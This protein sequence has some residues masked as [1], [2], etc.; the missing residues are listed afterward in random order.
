MANTVDFTVPNPGL[1]HRI[2]L[3]SGIIY[4]AVTVI[5]FVPAFYQQDFDAGF[6]VKGHPY[7][8]LDVVS[9]NNPW[10]FSSQGGKN[11]G[12]WLITLL[13]CLIIGGGWAFIEK[14][15]NNDRNALTQNDR[16][17]RLYNW[18][19]ILVRYQIAL[20]MSWFAIAKVFP[21][22]MPF[23]TLSQ[24]NTS[25]G[26]FAP[27]KLYWLTTGVSPFFEVFAG[28]FELIA[29][30]LIL[31]RRTA[32]L[33]A[34]MMIAILLSIWF[35]NIGY[36]AGVELASLHLLFLSAAL[37][38]KDADQFYNIL[39][40]HRQAVISY[41]QPSELTKQWKRAGRIVLKAAFIFL[42]LFYRGYHYEQLYAA[43]KT[44]KL[45]LDDGIKSFTGFYN[46]T[47]F[48]LNNKVLPYAPD[49]TVRWQNMAFEKFNTIS[50]GTAKPFKLRTDNKIRTTEYYGNIGRL[51]YG[52]EADTVKHILT[53]KNRADTTDALNLNYTA[54]SAGKFI[55]KG[56][57]PQKDSLY[58]VLN[59]V[60]KQY[61]LAIKRNANI[62]D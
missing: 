17:D 60:E 46:V 28:V 57:S 31:F 41:I 12:G 40:R 24:L 48:R 54:P 50:I 26:D 32:T 4:A 45:P 23:P 49:D 33:G 56:L 18:F 21:V 55:L 5:P 38:V 9:Q 52:Y 11:Y 15:I 29:T 37:L 43:G 20:R 25:L 39:I 42:F 30:V 44:F 14:Q 53:L 8:W 13:V 36:D 2:L 59:K 16:D 35:V 3:R 19:F 7:R 10:F 58:I 27:G 61:P 1:L 6:S 22:Q 62:T 34:L 47:E 51:Y